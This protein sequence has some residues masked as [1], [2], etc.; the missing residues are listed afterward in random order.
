MGQ[1]KVKISIFPQFYSKKWPRKTP[2]PSV[3]VFHVSMFCLLS[4]LCLFC[5]IFSS[6]PLLLD[7]LK[8][9]SGPLNDVYTKTRGRNVGCVIAQAFFSRGA[10]EISL[11]SRVLQ[12]NLAE[13]N[14]I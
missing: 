12:R 10:S 1:K 3:G 4:H 8:P 2:T 5:L 6:F 7:F 9:K 14:I 11:K 13:L